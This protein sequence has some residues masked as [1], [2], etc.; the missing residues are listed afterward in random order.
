MHLISTVKKKV[1]SFHKNIK[2]TLTI[3]IFPHLA[4]SRQN[5]GKKWPSLP[6]RK[7]YGYVNKT[8][9]D[10]KKFDQWY[11][12]ELLKGEWD[13]D[14]CLV[15]YCRA[16][17]V[18]LMHGCLKYNK[19]MTELTGWSPFITAS[20]VAGFAQFVLRA[21]Y[22]NHEDFAYLPEAGYGALNQSDFAIR[23]FKWLEE[24]HPERSYQHARTPHGEKVS[25]PRHHLLSMILLR[26]YAYMESGIPLTA[27]KMRR[28]LSKFTVASKRFTILEQNRCIILKLP[29][30]PF[31]LFTRTNSIW[32]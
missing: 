5:W 2:Y 29:W 18:I 26:S 19:I 21:N 28:R 1:T 16:D 25:T 8:P 22:L 24:K 10:Q 15:E 31:V 27:W 3:G 30:L 13:Q 32:R 14:K 7:Y 23:Y 11:E 4:N 20:T 6:D 12:S 9:A 17:V